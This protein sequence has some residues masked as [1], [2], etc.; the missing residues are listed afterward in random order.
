MWLT[1]ELIIAIAQQAESSEEDAET[2]GKLQKQ[3]ECSP[4]PGVL[5]GNAAL[6]IAIIVACAMDPEELREGEQPWRPYNP[7]S[8][9]M[10]KIGEEVMDED[11][12]PW[13]R[14]ELAA[15]AE[16]MLE[17][18]Y[19]EVCFLRARLHQVLRVVAHTG[20][21]HGVKRGTRLSDRMLVD[22][23]LSLMMGDMPDRA[24]QEEDEES[25]LRRTM[26]ASLKAAEEKGVASLAF[27]VMRDVDT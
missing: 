12:E 10:A 15:T 23:R 27:P 6:E 21:E 19:G 11:E 4:V 9:I 17:E 14:A 3:M 7:T 8:D 25:K 5:D 24:F 26:Q 22:T 2:A 1:L 13:D 16:K 18:V 20:V